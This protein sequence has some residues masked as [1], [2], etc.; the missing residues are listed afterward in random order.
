MAFPKAELQAALDT[1]QSE[2]DVLTALAQ[3]VEGI[4][5]ARIHID[6][7]YVTE[8]NPACEI[9]LYGETTEEDVIVDIPES[10]RVRFREFIILW[11]NAAGYSLL[12]ENAS[13]VPQSAFTQTLAEFQE[14]FGVRI[15]DFQSAPSS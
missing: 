1:A 13:I 10:L 11:L 8:N 7:D 6:S 3:F 4:D 5:G 2:T 14:Q 15:E 12:S 9:K